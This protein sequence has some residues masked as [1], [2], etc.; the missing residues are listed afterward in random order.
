VQWNIQQ[1]F[2]YK[3][4]AKFSSET[5]FEIGK[6]FA[7]IQTKVC[8]FTMLLSLKDEKLTRDLMYDG[9]DGYCSHMFTLGPLLLTLTSTNIQ[10]L[11]TDFD[12][13]L[14]TDRLTPSA[15]DW[16]LI[17]CEG[18]FLNV[19]QCLFSAAAN[20]Y[21]WSLCGNF[22]MPFLIVLYLCIKLC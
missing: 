15:S 3:F 21:S 2:Y 7:K 20:A 4:S 17:M 19:L 9:A 10:L 18:I 16:L 1:S 5:N 6:Y 8:L 22:S 11:Y 13:H 12:L 14:P